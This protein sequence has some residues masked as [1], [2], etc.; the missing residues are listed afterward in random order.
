MDRLESSLINRFFEEYQDNTRK[1]CVCY[2]F[3]GVFCDSRVYHP[4]CP[5]FPCNGGEIL[6]KID[7][8][9]LILF[10]IVG[11]DSLDLD[12][13]CCISLGEGLAFCCDS[14]GYIT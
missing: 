9:G 8:F 1:L 4:R 6:C 10:S 3:Q 12:D 5:I 2:L 13:D 7:R 14:A 11:F